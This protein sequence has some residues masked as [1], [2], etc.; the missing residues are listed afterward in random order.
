MS[1]TRKII[2]QNKIETLRERINPLNL[3]PN[4]QQNLSDLANKISHNILLFDNNRLYLYSAIQNDLYTLETRIKKCELEERKKKREKETIHESLKT[5][6]NYSTIS[7]PKPTSINLEI[8]PSTSSSFSL[9]SFFRCFGHRKDTHQE[10][11]KKASTQDISSEPISIAKQKP[12]PTAQTPRK[13]VFSS[14]LSYISS[15]FGSCFGA[16]RKGYEPIP[17][18]DNPTFSFRK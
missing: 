17:T 9:L 2:F 8:K 15:L 18:V 13:S 4:E 12:E 1:S 7:E 5:Q 11:V 16:R 14:G 3:E 6:N 10:A